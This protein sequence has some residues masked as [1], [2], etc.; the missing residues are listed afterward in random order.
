M[1]RKIFVSDVGWGDQFR[2]HKKLLQL[3]E[4]AARS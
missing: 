3:K 4:A 2:M 1:N